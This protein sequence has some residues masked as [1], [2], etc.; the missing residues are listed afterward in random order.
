MHGLLVEGG[1]FHL[2]PSARLILMA[3]IPTTLTN[4]QMLLILCARIGYSPHDA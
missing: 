4:H 2:Q 1:F 3:V